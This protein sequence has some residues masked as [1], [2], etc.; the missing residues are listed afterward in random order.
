[1]HGSLRRGPGCSL[2]GMW[3]SAFF[4][5][6]DK[7]K[8]SGAYFYWFNN[9]YCWQLPDLSIKFCQCLITTVQNL[10]EETEADAAAVKT[11]MNSIRSELKAEAT[12]VKSIVDMVTLQKKSIKWTN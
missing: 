2:Q 10:Q 7:T 8:S 11:M 3:C 1:M 9:T 12:Y 5:L 6:F 4:K